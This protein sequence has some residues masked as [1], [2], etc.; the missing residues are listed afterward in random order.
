MRVRVRVRVCKRA[1]MQRRRADGVVWACCCGC[2]VA[3][4]RSQPACTPHI[5]CAQ[6]AARWEKKLLRDKKGRVFLD[7]NSQCFVK[8]LDFHNL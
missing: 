7:V 5:V 3:P 8:I 2:A 6:L 4:A 1:A